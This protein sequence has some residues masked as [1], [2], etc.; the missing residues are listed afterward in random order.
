MSYR[1]L[2]NELVILVISDHVI[3]FCMYECHLWAH[4]CG[5][6]S[7]ELVSLVDLSTVLIGSMTDPA[8]T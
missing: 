3:H 4:F 1:F 2:K 7:T 5:I 6:S 8:P